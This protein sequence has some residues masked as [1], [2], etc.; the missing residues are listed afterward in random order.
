[1][2]FRLFLARLLARMQATIDNLC[3]ERDKLVGEQLKISG[4]QQSHQRRANAIA[5]ARGDYL[6]ICQ[7][8]P[9]HVRNVKQV[10]SA[11][12]PIALTA[13]LALFPGIMID[14]CLTAPERVA[15][16]RRQGFEE[17]GI[18]AISNML[19]GRGAVI[20]QTLKPSGQAIVKVRGFK[21]RRVQPDRR[22]RW[23]HRSHQPRILLLD[24]R[25]RL[26]HSSRN[27]YRLPFQTS[28]S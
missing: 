23:R 25:H 27:T 8:V 5:I 10:V 17:D 6:K 9:K 18:S 26:L 11:L 13:L 20:Q 12:Q 2:L 22:Q 28:T 1:M 24:V 21:F 4:H 3:D 15:Q 14:H 16:Q 7:S 19:C